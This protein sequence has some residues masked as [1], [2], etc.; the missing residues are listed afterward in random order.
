MIEREERKET[1]Q[2]T[3]IGLF[4]ESICVH[5]LPAWATVR[6]VVVRDTSRDSAGC[7]VQ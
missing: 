6:H 5:I 3:V 4:N 7:K 2:C 1:P